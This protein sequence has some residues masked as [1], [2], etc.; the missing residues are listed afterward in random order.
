MKK[1]EQLQQQIDK[2]RQEQTTLHLQY[3]Q[4]QLSVKAKG[5]VMQSLPVIYCYVF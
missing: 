2:L 4:L 3:D 5:I 1:V